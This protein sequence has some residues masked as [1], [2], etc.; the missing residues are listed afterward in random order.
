M[1]RFSLITVSALS[2][3]QRSD[4]VTW[5]RKCIRP[6][7]DLYYLPLKVIFWEKGGVRKPKGNRLTQVNRGNSPL[8][9]YTLPVYTGRVGYSVNMGIVCTGLKTEVVV[10]S[11]TCT[12]LIS[13]DGWPCFACIVQ[14]RLA[15]VRY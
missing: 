11:V 5:E 7:K 15:D 13:L 4:A 12:Q 6:V 9:R 14:V 3:S 2:F 10:L 1:R 8:T